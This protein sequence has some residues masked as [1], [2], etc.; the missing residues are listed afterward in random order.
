MR[1]FVPLLFLLP[2][3]CAMRAEAEEASV[4][5]VADGA[6]PTRITASYVLPATVDRELRDGPLDEKVGRLR[7]TIGLV[8]PATDKVGPA[9]FGSY[10]LTARSLS[11]RPA[12]GLVRG[13]TY[14]AAA[15][16]GAQDRPVAT[17]DYQVPAATTATETTVVRSIAPS[18]ASLPA[19]VLRFYVTFSRPMREGREVL[20]RIRLYDEAG[21]E[22]RSPWRDLELWNAD[23][24]R[25]S[26]FLH[27]GR[28]KQG[29]NLREQLGP[30]LEPNRKYALV[31]GGDLRDAQGTPLGRDV[32]HA[33]STTAEVRSRIDVAAWRVM[34][35]ASGSSTPLRVEFDRALD[36]A[37][38]VRLV[39]VEDGAG[40][41]LP[42]AATLSDGERVW[43]F[44]PSVPWRA[45]RYAV[46]ADPVLEDQAGNTPVRIFDNDLAAPT[47]EVLPPQLRREFMPR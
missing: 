28:I 11:F 12:F 5:I 42:G 10:T 27:P 38:A 32:R 13:A 45:E 3:L 33:F 6:D 46:V 1:L 26:L 4:R 47:V 36:A 19:N 22:I 37:L 31:I 41:E 24:T 29:V 23:A 30:L 16:D 34:S 40:N 21:N 43:N 35:P 17:I 14:R 15:F 18:G 7:L 20:E 39:R 9:I 44:T 8:D 2:T 25:L